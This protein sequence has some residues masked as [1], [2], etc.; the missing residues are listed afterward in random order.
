MF[1]IRRSGAHEPAPLP[2]YVA[3]FAGLGL[4]GG[5]GVLL[6]QPIVLL[7]QILQAQSLI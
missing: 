2:L 3:H 6:F 1:P 5:L 7:T 4:A